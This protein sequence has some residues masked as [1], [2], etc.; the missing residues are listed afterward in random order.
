[1]YIRGLNRSAGCELPLY[2]ELAPNQVT[3][4]ASRSVKDPHSINDLRIDWN[5]IGH[6]SNTKS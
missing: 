5:L 2:I 6:T 3:Q 1:M 4:D